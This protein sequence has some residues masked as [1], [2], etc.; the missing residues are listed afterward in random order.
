LKHRWNFV[1][2]RTMWRFVSIGTAKIFHSSA[3]LIV[4]CRFVSITLL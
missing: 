4:H 1:F 3:V 2:Q